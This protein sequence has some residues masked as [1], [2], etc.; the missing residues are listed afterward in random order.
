MKDSETRS[1]TFPRSH[2]LKRRRLIRTLFDRGREDVG[3]IARG[4][5]RLVFRLASPEEVGADVPLQ[6]GFAP[7]RTR[8]AVQRNR[9]RRLLRETYRLHQ[10]V[11]TDPLSE[12]TDV[13]TVMVL[14]RGRPD[15]AGGAIRRDLPAALQQLAERL[16]VPSMS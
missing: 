6:I 7:G 9:I 10:H 5:V 13:L 3:T 4:C 2:R 12:C 1:F 8:T 16:R 15:K 11:L 14:F